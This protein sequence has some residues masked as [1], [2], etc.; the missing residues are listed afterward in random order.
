[1][2]QIN[3]TNFSS[4]GGPSAVSESSAPS[5]VRY[6]SL[7]NDGDEAVVRIMHDSPEDFD[8]IGTHQ[9]VVNGRNRRV[10]CL[11][12][13][14]DPIEKCPLCE[15]G[16]PLQYRLYVHLLEYVHGDDGQIQVIPK[17]WERPATF[18]NTL[19]N[20]C[21]EYGNL[22]DCIFRIKRN[23]KAGSTSTTYDIL[24]ANPKVYT[25]VAYPKKSELLEEYTA[26]GNACMDMS[27][28]DMVKLATEESGDVTPPSF[29]APTA[30]RRTY[31]PVGHADPVG[32]KGEPGVPV[33]AF[34]SDAVS[35]RPSPAPAAP[36]AEPSSV[37]VRPRRW[38]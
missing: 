33:T 4:V 23:G 25:D 22:S 38:Y 18:A 14:M 31:E 10:S 21:D 5:Y 30:P 1:M 2:A 16:T 17:V 28:A 12:D 8:I 35:E 20:Y 24:Y 19:K 7:K 34:S 26:L 27:Y 32:A 15:N 13:P 11:R 3:W 9:V 29:T 6:F 36:T 37:P